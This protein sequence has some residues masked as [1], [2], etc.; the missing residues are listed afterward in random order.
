M[1]RSF[2]ISLWGFGF[3]VTVTSFFG[4][5]SPVD[6]LVCFAIGSL[7]GLIF[8]TPSYKRAIK[9]AGSPPNR[10][11]N[12][13]FFV[14]FSLTIWVFGIRRADTPGVYSYFSIHNLWLPLVAWLVLQLLVIVIT[15]QAERG[16]EDRDLAKWATKYPP[17]VYGALFLVMDIVALLAKV[18]HAGSGSVI[19]LDVFTILG[20]VALIVVAGIHQIKY[21]TF[22]D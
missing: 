9:A 2:A 17:I 5:G 6:C 4:T 18:F 12:I 14:V 3:M 21:G 13:G 15:I 8:T 16:G 10:W 20:V 11:A 22:Y 19:A 7:I 1:F